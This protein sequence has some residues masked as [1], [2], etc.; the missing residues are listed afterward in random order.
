MRYWFRRRRR[1]TDEEFAAEIE[2]HLAHEADERVERGVPPDEARFAALRAFGNVTSARERYYESGRLLFWDRLSQDVRYAVRL[3]VRTPLLTAAIVSTLAL[4]IG[5]A[6]A[7]FS[8]LQ[9]VVLRPLPYAAP[10]RLVQVFETGPR[11]GGEADWVAFPNFRDWRRENRVFD[12][13]AAYRYT[14]LT[15]VDRQGAD[16]TIG[17]EATDDLFGVLGVAPIIGRAFRPGDDRPGAERVAVLSGGFWQRRFGGDPHVIG[18]T[19]TIDGVSHTVVGVMPA[20]FRF[21]LNVAFDSVLPIDLWIPVRQSGDLEDRFSHNFWAVGRL[22]PGVRLE[23]AQA[24]MRTIA[25]N[26]ARAHPDSN[27]DFSVA[28]IPLGEYV[29]GNMRPALLVLLGAVGLVLLLTCANVA[30]LLL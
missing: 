5:I 10:D 27:E 9:A 15:V 16:A 22:K 8:L 18:R 28:V 25:D 26:L 24:A 19:V 11:P 29:W 4:G 13:L 3:L 1:P 7:L 17:L 23:Q 21:P 20:S 14:Q 6:S 12:G 2:S 30:N